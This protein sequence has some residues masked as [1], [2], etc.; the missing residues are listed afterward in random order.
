MTYQKDI[1]SDLAGI[2]HTRRFRIC[3]KVIF[4][5]LVYRCAAT[6]G[7]VKMVKRILFGAGAWGAMVYARFA[8]AE[9]GQVWKGLI[10]E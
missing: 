4:P 2:T 3:I 1:F 7:T 8:F 10:K 9:R 6:A 5:I